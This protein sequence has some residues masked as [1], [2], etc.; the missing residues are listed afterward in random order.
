MSHLLS[1]LTCTAPHP[2]FAINVHVQACISTRTTHQSQRVRVYPKLCIHHVRTRQE[3]CSTSHAHFNEA[4][5][6][7]L[8]A[9]IPQFYPSRL[10]L[11]RR[12][13]GTILRWVLPREVLWNLVA[14]AVVVTLLST[15]PSAPLVPTNAKWALKTAATAVSSH[16]ASISGHSA[17]ASIDKVWLLASGLV[18]FTLSFFLTQSY[19]FWRS[20][21]SLTRR[22]Q[23][24]LNDIGLLC[25]SVAERDARGE[26]TE[27]SRAMIQLL[28]RYVRLFTYLFY[29]SCTA[30]FAV[31]RTPRGL[32]ELVRRG[33]I[34]SA[35]RD[36][37]LRSSMGHNAVLEWMMTLINS[38][39]ADGR[40]CGSA[41]GGSPVATQISLQARLT[42]LRAS[43]AGIEDEL[44][45]RMPLAY[46][47]LVQIMADLLIL[48][49]PFALIHSVG[50]VG[51]VIG[52]GLVTLFHSSILNLAKMFLDPLNNDDY[53]GNIGIN[54]ATL[55]QETNIGS[56]RWRKSSVWVPPSTLPIRDVLQPM[57]AVRPATVAHPDWPLEPGS[58]PQTLLGA[59]VPTHPQ[60][61]DTEQDDRTLVESS[62]ATGRSRSTEGQQDPSDV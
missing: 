52:T 20:V 29:G 27:S 46:T 53:S 15:V 9:V 22:V 34:T 56:E 61:G 7:S 24:R 44:T 6:L 49:T 51:A 5:P 18:S 39:L 57:R 3:K 2:S 10:W 42:E 45:G 54:V 35:E 17:L 11:W 23:G 43:F 48:C 26:F 36:A 12:W 38:A 40:L 31:L 47:Q 30:K 28:A 37:L 50:G 16:S 8:C 14:S 60:A 1:L 55:I 33:A 25:A 21:L 59:S 58:V 62:W 41:S 13:N 19:A 4:F 32:G